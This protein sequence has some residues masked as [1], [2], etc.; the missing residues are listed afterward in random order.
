MGKIMA[1]SKAN[2]SHSQS[3]DG[4]ATS[5]RIIL[6]VRARDITVN[7]G[8]EEPCLANAVGTCRKID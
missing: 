7:T 5:K 8:S 2:T 3:G 4:Q 1:L 6:F